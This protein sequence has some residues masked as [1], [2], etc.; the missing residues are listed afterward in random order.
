MWAA[1]NPVLYDARMS[2]SYWT[3]KRAAALAAIYPSGVPATY[4]D[5]TTPNWDQTP[6]WVKPLAGLASV[7]R[8][9]VTNA[10]GRSGGTPIYAHL[11]LPSAPFA[12]RCLVF[13]AGHGDDT[14]LH[15]GW[16]SLDYVAS[17]GSSVILRMLARGWL[18]LA[19]DLPN[20]GLQPLPQAA[21][22]NGALVA[23]NEWFFH[24]PRLSAEPFDAP[25]ITRLYTDHVIIA[26][27]RVSADYPG[28][29]FDLLG[30]SG[31]G[32]AMAMLATV[33]SRFRQVHL[34]QGGRMWY[35][36][37]GEPFD[38]EGYTAN[39]VMTATQNGAGGGY[40]DEVAV[41]ATFPNRLTVVHAA[42]ADE[43]YG[44]DH[45][46]WFDWITSVAPWIVGAT[47]ATSTL[48]FHRKLTGAHAI[49]AP[50]AAWIEDCLVTGA[51]PA[52]A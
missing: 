5:T 9:T 27:N 50:Q 39:D 34:C 17:D 45:S 21:V 43:Y 3:G 29:G 28:I 41:G 23:Q 20:Y 18:V 26:M 38:W 31:G 13:H 32:A 48:Y 1:L 36:E 6:M 40:H 37:S 30:H 35:V 25:S 14:Q 7:T 46:A 22:I 19:V 51:P 42:D 8:Y 47:N 4:P 10:G 15:G 33:E 2:A 11:L 12:G 49:D 52:L 44:D 16:S 24:T